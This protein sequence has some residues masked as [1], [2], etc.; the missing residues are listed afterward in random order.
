MIKSL[1]LFSLLISGAAM[2]KIK[3]QKV[4]YKSGDLTFEGFM[5][6]DTTY[7]G[8]LPGVMVVHNWM[9]VSA[10][11]E[12]KVIELAK[13]GYIAFAGD[14]YGK[15]VRPSNSKEAGE[16]AT[17]YKSD[18]KLLRE[19][20]NLAITELRKMSNIDSKKIFVLGYCFG[21][22]TAIEVA[23]SGADILGAV[24]FHGG[25][26]PSSEDKNIKGKV[27]VLH[28]AIDPYVPQKD[29]DG[30]LK[31]MNEA[32]VDYQMVAYANA[33]HSFTEKAA[34]E[35]NSK[36]AAYNELADKRSWVAMKEFLRELS[37]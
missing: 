31:G 27:L 33:V 22:T 10:E 19:R 11:T 25:L 7:K 6:Y 4:E 30:F 37:K 18:L 28:G 2:A 32:K 36:G 16:L 9:G 34:G 20:A 3:T 13:L 15:G 1:L 26:T 35:D 14:I 5:A 12:S 21:G 23:R 8:K 24:S 17:K 29:I